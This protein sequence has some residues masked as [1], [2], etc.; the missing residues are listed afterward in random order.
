M[1]AEERDT[2]APGPE[3]GRQGPTGQQQPA[4]L[5][6]PPRLCLCPSTN[7]PNSGQNHCQHLSPALRPLSSLQSHTKGSQVPQARYAQ[8]CHNHFP[9]FFPKPLL[10][11]AFISTVQLSEPSIWPWSSPTPTTSSQLSRL[12]GSTTSSGIFLHPHSHCL[13]FG[14]GIPGLDGC[15][16]SRQGLEPLAWV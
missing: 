9:I 12:V 4:S 1:T 13:M 6:K 11:L 3:Q 2:L 15:Y 16:G 7:Q 14:L 5:P 8:S 10:S